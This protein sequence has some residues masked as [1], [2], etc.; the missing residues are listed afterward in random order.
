M[1]DWMMICTIC[2]VFFF[3]VCS[4]STR[5]ISSS[6]KERWDDTVNMVD[7]WVMA[8]WEVLELFSFAGWD[9]F[10][11]SLVECRNGFARSV[12]FCFSCLVFLQYLSIADDTRDLYILHHISPVFPCVVTECVHDGAFSWASL[13]LFPEIFHC[14]LTLY[15][16]PPFRNAAWKWKRLDRTGYIHDGLQIGLYLY[17][18]GDLCWWCFLPSVTIHPPSLTAIPGCCMEMKEI[19]SRMI[20]SFSLQYNSVVGK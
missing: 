6:G 17:M 15:C 10:A 1:S 8:I 5:C 14:V 18:Y 3:F 11:C 9:I 12:W 2:L 20:R 4:F 13:V 7:D 16:L 19:F